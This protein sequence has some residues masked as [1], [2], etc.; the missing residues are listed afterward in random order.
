MGKD[1]LSV[2]LLVGG[3]H[4]RQSFVFLFSPVK[5]MGTRSLLVGTQG[6]VGL[7]WIDNFGLGHAT[8][9]RSVHEVPIAGR[10]FHPV[11]WAPPLGAHMQLSSPSSAGVQCGNQMLEYRLFETHKKVLGTEYGQWV[12]AK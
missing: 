5:F 8:N 4:C 10:G 9:C 7:G 1:A 2:P 3:P 11:A 6:A 12:R